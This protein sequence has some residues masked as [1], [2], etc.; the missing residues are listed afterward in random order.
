[1]AGRSSRTATVRVRGYRRAQGQGPR[2]HRPPLLQRR[3]SGMDEE[4]SRVHAELARVGEDWTLVD[5][6]L[7]SNGSWV[8][9]ERLLGRRR[10][11]DGDLVRF[12]A[13]MVRFRD[14]RRVESRVTTAG[15]RPIP[16]ALTP[17][18]RRVLV[19]LCRPYKGSPR[20]ATPATN[21]AIARELVVTVDA[22]KKQLRTLFERA[23]VEGSQNRKRTRLVER[24]FELRL[25]TDKD[26]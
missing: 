23:G 14:P 1:M 6:G 4:V 2:A 21:D 3:V 12:G 22:V 17:A 20:F 10:L 25:V 15:E 19:A 5:D 8:N 11:Q 16:V 7:S 18:Q 24:A 26:L 13:T 9:G